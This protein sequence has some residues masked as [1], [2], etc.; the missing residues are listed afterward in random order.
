M[1]TK[2]GR[3]GEL[4][5]YPKEVGTEKR[6]LPSLHP[7]WSGL[8]HAPKAQP[9]AS[10][11]LSPLSFTDSPPV[12]LQTSNSIRKSGAGTGARAAATREK[13]ALRQEAEAD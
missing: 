3:P 5:S 8:H 11:P 12:S 9:A 6:F 2:V 4:A 13:Q 7:W 1:D 10:G